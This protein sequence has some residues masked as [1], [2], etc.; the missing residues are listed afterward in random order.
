MVKNFDNFGGIFRLSQLSQ[1]KIISLPIAFILLID[2]HWISIYI[3][4]NSVEIMDSSG[5]LRFAVKRKELRNF[6]CPLIRYK[7]FH[8]SSQL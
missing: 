3:T 5:F 1:I 4:E 8:V 7:S 2:E 6:L